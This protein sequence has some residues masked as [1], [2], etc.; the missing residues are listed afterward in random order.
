MRSDVTTF[1]SGERPCTESVRRENLTAIGE[2]NVELGRIRDMNARSAARMTNENIMDGHYS[3]AIAATNSETADVAVDAT[4][5]Y[6]E[7]PTLLCPIP[8]RVNPNETDACRRTNE[9][10]IRFGLIRD[11]DGLKSFD[12]LQIPDFVS[13]AY[14]YAQPEDLQ[15]VM[16]WTAWGFIADD[17][18]DAVT[19]LE[20][21]LD[22]HA[23]CVAV[24]VDEKTAESPAEVALADIRDR[25][26]ARSNIHCLLR[27][28]DTA[29][30]WFDSMYIESFN[31]LH[32]KSLSQKA[33][34]E[35]REISV[36]M[37]TEYALFDVTHQC[38]LSSSLWYDPQMRSLMTLTANVI[39]Y[40]N[41]IFSV[42]K[43][44]RIGDPHNLVLCITEE[45]KC[46]LQQAANETARIHNAE[47]KRFLEL[48][49]EYL[50]CDSPARN[51]PREATLF[52]DLL[53]AWIRANLDWALSSERYGMHPEMLE[54]ALA[55]SSSM[56]AP[57]IRDLVLPGRSK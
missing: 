56:V 21:L 57:I 39:G 28:A 53:R 3:L 51:P 27:F 38:K 33:Y 52:V 16:D 12:A 17:E 32:H 55:P 18:A 1:R 31:R 41:D 4:A 20:V 26:L 36:G 8:P 47:M 19:D 44:R 35:L 25:I 54:V 15:I 49:S 43:E 30:Q 14:P 46:S 10:L 45:R 48:E 37:Y 6:A 23:G 13:R 50:G 42:A 29:K 24:L 34:R 22:F 11:E 7:L 2:P 9:W 40:A 5:M